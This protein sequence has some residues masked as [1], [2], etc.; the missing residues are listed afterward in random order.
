MNQQVA[1][2]TGIREFRLTEQSLP[3]PPPGQVQVQIKAVGICGSDLHAYSEGGIS[4][5]ANQYPMVLGHEPSGIIV[6]VGAGVADWSIGD[7]VAMEPAVFCYHCEACQTGHHNV[8][9]SIKFHSVSGEEP[10]FFRE[11]INLPLDQLLRIPDHLAYEHAAL[12][13]PLSVAVHSM[14]FAAIQMGESVAI[15]GAGPI[16]LLTIAAAKASGAGRIWV[17]E[18]RKHRRDLAIAMGADDVIEPEGAAKE[19]LKATG[20]RGVDCTF[21]CAAKETTTNVAM[22]I[23]R[24]AGR[25]VLTGIHSERLVPFDVLAMRRKELVIYNVRRA[26]REIQPALDLLLSGINRFA[27]IVTHTRPLDSIHS[28][29]ELTE[30]CQDGV[31]KMVIRPS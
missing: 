28:A 4:G 24:N 19:I 6:K 13:E 25:L 7:R 20:K 14:R 10:G 17:I 2:L 16:G 27:Q 31:G 3:D 22:E 8:C 18:P 15:F 9:H 11:F 1:E 23:S 12:V 21:D 29:F 30:A 26:N 5:L